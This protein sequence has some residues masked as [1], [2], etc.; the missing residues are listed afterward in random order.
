MNEKRSGW[1]DNPPEVYSGLDGPASAYANLGKKVDRQIPKDIIVKDL[2]DLLRAMPLSDTQVEELFLAIS[3]RVRHKVC[4]KCMKL[5]PVVG[6]K[7][8][9]K[10]DLSK[11]KSFTCKE[12]KA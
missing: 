3:N 7:W 2:V 10:L 6:G 9:A 5:K 4:D 12:C 11:P 8:E 1:G